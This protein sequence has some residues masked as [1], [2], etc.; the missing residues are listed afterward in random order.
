MCTLP[1][2]GQ[3]HWEL[4]HLWRQLLDFKE[5]TFFCLMS[6]SYC[7]ISASIRFI[8]G[9]WSHIW[10]CATCLFMHD[11]SFFSEWFSCSDSTFL[12][13]NWFERQIY[14]ALFVMHA[15]LRDVCDGY[16]MGTQAWECSSPVICSTSCT[17]HLK[18]LSIMHSHLCMVVHVDI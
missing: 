1:H 8:S 2:F 15:L 3:D 12:G 5:G 9:W 10:L 18:S 16:P 17:Q 14:G 11:S 6:V 4:F 7:S 13:G